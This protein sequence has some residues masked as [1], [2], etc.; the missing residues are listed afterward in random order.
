MT[1]DQDRPIVSFALLSHNET[2]SLRRLLAS[3]AGRVGVEVR[4]VDDFSDPP[5][6]AIIDEFRRQY[7]NVHLYQRA[8][9]K[10]FAA[11]RNFIAG[12]CRG[13]YIGRVDADETLPAYFLDNLK[14]I[15]GEIDAGGFDAA[16]F[17]RI[18]LLGTEPDESFRKEFVAAYG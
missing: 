5:T 6:L 10:N 14:T 15:V 12:K 2:D 13:R 9:R 16:A 4:I 7:A 1:T 18:N 17:P 11:Q 3:V 8:L